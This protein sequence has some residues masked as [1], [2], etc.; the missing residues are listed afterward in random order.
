[1]VKTEHEI[2]KL[3][4]N[5]THGREVA[6]VHFRSDGL[7]SIPLGEAIAAKVLR[8]LVQRYPFAAGFKYR[9]MKGDWVIITNFDQNARPKEITCKSNRNSNSK[10]SQTNE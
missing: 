9:N 3:I 4:L 8:D 5:V 6:G 2:N 7:H 1:Q 10:D